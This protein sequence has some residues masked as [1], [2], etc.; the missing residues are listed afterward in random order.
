MESVPVLGILTIVPFFLLYVVPKLT[1]W[2][3][4][5]IHSVKV[6]NI[7]I[8]HGQSLLKKGLAKVIHHISCS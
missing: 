7:Y 8:N 4:L 1:S 2:N 6:K 3:P 5:K